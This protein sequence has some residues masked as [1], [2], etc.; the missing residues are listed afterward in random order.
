MDSDSLN[1]TKNELLNSFGK[2]FK[3]TLEWFIP[4]LLTFYIF[5]TT[6]TNERLEAITILKEARKAEQL[7]TEY[8]E[9]SLR[10]EIELL[11]QGQSKLIE[12]YLELQK[13]TYKNC[14]RIK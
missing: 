3:T 7:R 6:N 14:P 12:L 10:R 4:M 8:V 5:H 1:K 13:D 9:T 11:E 2:S